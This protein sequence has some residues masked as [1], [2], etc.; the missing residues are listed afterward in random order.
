MRRRA[1]IA[2]LGAVAMP[3]SARARK[4]P[5]V[6]FFINGTGSGRGSVARLTRHRTD[7]G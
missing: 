1:F 2:G 3:F 7:G 5:L 6:G 4:R